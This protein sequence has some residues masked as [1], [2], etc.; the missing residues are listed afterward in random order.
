MTE[1]EVIREKETNEILNIEENIKKD[2]NVND[3]NNKN[4]IIEKISM[5]IKN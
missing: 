1:S 5:M 2:G 3:G 4:L